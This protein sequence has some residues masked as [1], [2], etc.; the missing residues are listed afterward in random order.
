[1]RL[2]NELEP[3]S[4]VALN[5]LG[6]AFTAAGERDSALATFDRAIAAHPGSAVLH[7]NRANALL[8][9][10]RTEEADAELRRAA[11][12]DSTL[13]AA[14]LLLI[15][16]LSQLGQYDSAIVVMQSVV[17]DQP[18]VTNLNRLGSLF[19][20]AGDSGRAGQCYESA[21]RLDSTYVPVLYNLSVLFAARRESAAARVLAERAFRLRP[22]LNA[23]R[24]LHQHLSPDSVPD[25]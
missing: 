23:V 20:A 15:E 1:L 8:A 21:L 6:L 7:L 5:D 11:E 13:P 22:D 25:P 2:A 3:N 17:K 10:G 24:E 14:R 19:I 16:R 9:A 18:T 4:L 12:L